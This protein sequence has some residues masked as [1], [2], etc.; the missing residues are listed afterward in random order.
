[1]ID[2]YAGMFAR[3]PAMALAMATFLLSLAGILPF[4]G[5][6]AKFLIFRVLIEGGGLWLAIAMVLNTVVS[7]FYYAAVVKKM[8][9]DK[10]EITTAVILPRVLASPI[11]L[12]AVAVL[13]GGVLPD[14]F[15]RLA[16]NSHF[17]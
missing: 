17:F 2:D 16:T 4:A 15:Y 9:F 13:V 14:L 12:T 6:W 1:M 5:F 8:F 11:V 7:L 10:S 3:S